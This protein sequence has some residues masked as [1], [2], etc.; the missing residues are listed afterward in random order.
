MNET[1]L[2]GKYYLGDPNDVLPSKIL[3]GIW[4]NEYNLENG[5]FKFYDHDFVV[6]NT[7][8]GDG[9]FKDTKNREYII[10]SGIIAL[11][12][13]NLIDDMDSCKNG[14]I[15]NF[16]KIV[17]FIYDAGIFYIKSGKKYIQIDTVNSEE[18]D[19]EKEEH[20]DNEDGEYISK[21][22]FNDSDTDSI[23][24]EN[25]EKPSFFKKF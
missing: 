10:N 8:D 7:H 9:T 13:I 14:H 17:N 23:E 5:K 18:Y 24:A 4:K 15:F 11:V 12:H 16:N 6:H 2:P 3:I 20:C 1:L 22:L 25:D 21:T 19:S